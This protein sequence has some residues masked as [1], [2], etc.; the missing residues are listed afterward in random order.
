MYSIQSSP[1]NLTPIPVNA[2]LDLAG[3]LPVR[4]LD[5]F[6]E[7]SAET[8][9]DTEST[10]NNDFSDLELLNPEICLRRRMKEIV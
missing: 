10:E 8:S 4:L 1:V 7:N 2:C 9:S 5:H 3:Q 6:M